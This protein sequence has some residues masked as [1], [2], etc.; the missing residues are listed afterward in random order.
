MSKLKQGDIILIN[1]EKWFINYKSRYNGNYSCY[2]YFI[3]NI[4]HATLTKKEVES[5][6]FLF[7]HFEENNTDIFDRKMFMDNKTAKAWDNRFKNINEKVVDECRKKT[8]EIMD[9]F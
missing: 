9:T 8:K 2:P 5:G 1:G 3:S 7:N 6:S 4:I